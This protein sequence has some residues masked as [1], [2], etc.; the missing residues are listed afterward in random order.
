LKKAAL[1]TSALLTVTLLLTGCAA[2]APSSGSNSADTATHAATPIPKVTP[3]KLKPIPIPV[4]ATPYQSGQFQKGI[5]VYWHTVGSSKSQVADASTEA[6]EILNYVVGLGANSVSITFPFCVNGTRSTVTTACSDTPTPNELGLVI[7][8]AEARGLHVMVRPLLAESESG[9]ALPAWRGNIDP[10]NP[11]GWFGTYSTFMQS[12][13]PM[14]VKYNVPEYVLGVEMVSM[15]RFTAQWQGLENAVRA[16]GYTGALS[17][18][19]NWNTFAQMPFQTLGMDA[20][21]NFNLPDSASQAQ[22]TAALTGWYNQYAPYGSRLT[23]QEVGIA[24]QVGAYKDSVNWGLG[25]TSPS[26][27]NNVQAAWFTGSCAAA[28]ATHMQGIYY[29]M[30]DSNANP[31]TADQATESAGMWLDRGPTIQAIEWCF[32]S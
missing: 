1:Y 19:E 8:A 17:Y 31:Y 29:W 7:A 23:I 2:L 4:V 30:I 22:V 10:P 3:A 13:V 16:A 9:M 15:Q 18:S 32:A 12:Y 5:Q 24:Q 14:L 26:L 28:K 27:Q 11:I 20:Y 21:P 25:P 6:T